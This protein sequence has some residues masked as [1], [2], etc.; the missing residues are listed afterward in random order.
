MVRL[1]RVRFSEDPV[2]T[3]TA[4]GV[5]VLLGAIVVAF[6]LQQLLQR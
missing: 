3:G 5:L 2:R 1:S 4:V 6:S